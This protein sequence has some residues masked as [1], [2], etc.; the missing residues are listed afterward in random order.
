MSKRD[1][2]IAQGVMKL[3]VIIPMFNAASTIEAT[4]KSLLSQRDDSVSEIVVVDDGSTDSCQ[5]LVGRLVL[6]DRRVILVHQ[7]HRGAPSAVNRGILEARGDLVGLV[8]SDAEVSEEWASR[9]LPEFDDP[10]VAAAGGT[11]KLANPLSFWARVG[12]YEV[13]HRLS[14]LRGKYVDHLSTCNVIYR[15]SILE[16]LGP[17]NTDLRIGYDVDMSYRIGRAGK[18]MVL[19]RDAVCLNHWREQAGGYF[20]QQFRYAYDRL[21]LAAR[22]QEKVLGDNI[23]GPRMLVQVPILMALLGATGMC[24][25]FYARTGE[26]VWLGVPVIGLVAILVERMQEAIVIL[27]RTGDKEMLVLPLVHLVRN[28]AWALAAFVWSTGRIRLLARARRGS[29]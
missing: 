25:W 27:R 24:S 20:R 5:E 6:D 12:G 10:E 16:S 26:W 11:I 22:Y 23:V 18:R 15:R 7:D 14:R 17:F 2:S 19:R 4:L 29:Q 28:W 9:L 21:E 13:D 1:S 8:D 3:S